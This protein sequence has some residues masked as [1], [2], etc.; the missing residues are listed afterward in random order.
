[1]LR[2]AGNAA[3][4]GSPMNGMAQHPAG[5]GRLQGWALAVGALCLGG[6]TAAA[7]LHAGLREAYFRAYLFSWI[8]CLGL[9]LGSL[10]WMMMHHLMRANWSR[11]V[12][13]PAEAASLNLGLLAVLFIP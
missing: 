2:R 11:A 6:A 9:S 7:Y 1:R 4:E 12:L 5:F 8:F 3:Q 13:R 10:M